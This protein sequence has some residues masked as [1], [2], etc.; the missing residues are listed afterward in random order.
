[1]EARRVAV[2]VALTL[3]APRAQAQPVGPRLPTSQIMTDAEANDVHGVESAVHLNS[4]ALVF[5]G[6]E[7]DLERVVT[8]YL[9]VSLQGA[10]EWKSVRGTAGDEISARVWSAGLEL[11]FYAFRVAPFGLYL[12]P[13]FR[14]STGTTVGG[15][16]DDSASGYSTGV[17]VG[18]SFALG[19]CNVKVG[20]GGIWR[21]VPLAPIDSTNMRV[22]STSMHG[23]GP[24]LDLDLGFAF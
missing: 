21:D 13:F 22:F 3:C 17:T 9:S 24:Q 11:H 20:A 7:A 10:Y 23:F 19:P 2:L 4:A 1:M 6:I 15:R 5:G 14:G 12:A 18:W 8:D 16:V